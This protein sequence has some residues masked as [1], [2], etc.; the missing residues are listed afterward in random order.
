[1]YIEFFVLFFY[2]WH[3][4]HC[5]LRISHQV[6]GIPFRRRFYFF[7]SNI[8]GSLYSLL[9][10]HFSDALCFSLLAIS[11]KSSLIISHIIYESVVLGITR[12]L[13]KVSSLYLRFIKFDVLRIHNRNR[14]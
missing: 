8:A 10:N 14:R 4:L 7:F 6:F 12:N 13:L 2:S 9:T 5:Y 3:N 1:M 11:S